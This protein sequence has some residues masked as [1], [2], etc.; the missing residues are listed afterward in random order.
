MTIDKKEKTT[1]MEW[2]NRYSDE[3]DSEFC[4]R[5]VFQ[6]I[7]GDFDDCAPRAIKEIIE[8][9]RAEIKQIEL[10]VLESFI[11]NMPK[12]YRKR[13]HNWVVVN[14]ILLPALGQTSCIDKCK[15]LG[16]KPFGYTLERVKDD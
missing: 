6:N 8:Q 9:Q 16:I 2:L 15:E 14:D 4:K 7:C 12:A 13:T 11:R 5:C 10:R 3:Y 1:A